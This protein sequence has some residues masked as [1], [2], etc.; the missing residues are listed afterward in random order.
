VTCNTSRFAEP[1]EPRRHFAGDL[2]PDLVTVADPSLQI[3]HGW[4]YGASRA[5][6]PNKVLL[7]FANAV[8][9]VGEGALETHADQIVTH[10]VDGQEVPVSQR[11]YQSGGGFRSQPSGVLHYHDQ[12]SHHHFHFEDFAEYNLRAVTPGN[13]VGPI[14]RTGGKAGFCL[15][16]SYAYNRN[17]PGAPQGVVYGDECY[18]TSGISVGWAD[19]YGADLDFQWIDVTNLPPGQYWLEST[20]DPDNKL[21]EL[22]ETNNTTRILVT[23][24]VPLAG[25]IN[26]D[27][28]AD[29]LDFAV[30]RNNFGYSG[31]SWSG[32]DLTGDRKVD[33]EDFQVFE[34]AFGGAPRPA[35]GPAAARPP[36]RAPAPAAVPQTRPVSTTPRK[37]SAFAF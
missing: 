6:M 36:A 21:L 13:G 7:R 2:L 37:R 28:R 9:N 33:F 20:A 30:L 29:P 4:R 16:D 25:D 11:I 18:P 8:A 23:L 27:G 14:V 12:G 5:W 34:L 22:N 24:D 15:R 17:L 32:G 35:P 26:G 1:L 3:M 19:Y 10:P 31:L